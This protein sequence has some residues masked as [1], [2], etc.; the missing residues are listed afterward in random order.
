[1]QS[2]NGSPF[3]SAKGQFSRM[4]VLLMSLGVQPVFSRPGKPQDNGRHERMHRDLKADILRHRG[5]TLREQQRFFDRFR[6]TFNNERPHESIGSD[7]PARRYRR[8][9]RPFPRKPRQ[10]DY[11]AHWEKRKVGRNG[12]VS[13]HQADVFVSEPFNGHTIAFEPVDVDVWRIRFHEFEIG[14]FNERT[15]TVF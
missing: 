3:G 6:R 4:S 15:R 9:P 1:M 12:V 2:D 13:W 11:P 5:S 10:P 14:T 8:S 7:R